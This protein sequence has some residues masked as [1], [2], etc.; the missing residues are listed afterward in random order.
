M[1]H[2]PTILYHWRRS[3]TTRAYSIRDVDRCVDA[4]RR[5]VTE[6][7]ATNDIAADVLPAPAAPMWQRIRYRLPTPAPKVSAIVPTKNHAELLETCVNGLLRNTDYPSL[8]IA[9]VDHDS[10]DMATKIL[11]AKFAK[12]F[13]VRILRYAGLF[14][15]SAINNFA[16]ANTDGDVLAFLNNDIEIMHPDWLREMVSQVMRP[17]IGA[18]GAKL[19]YPD[20]NIQHAGVI[21][22]IGGVAGHQYCHM[23]HD[24]AG[25]NGET[26][27]VRELS[28]V[29]GACMLVRRS[30]FIEAG[31]FD[32]IN[33]P[34]AF[35]DIDFCLRLREHGYRN[36]F[37]PFA[38][39]IHHESASRG[40]EVTPEKQE[41]FRRECEY[42]MGRW[43]DTLQRDPYFNP[44]RSLKATN[45]DL[46][47]PPRISR[48]WETPP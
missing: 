24:F 30:A 19:Y 12:D 35:N 11:L 22:G 4:A 9:I 39:L 6:F 27:L 10:D 34:V 42:M 43:G 18:V 44:N 37:T 36:I 31:G 15:F 41:R 48:P 5:A 32:P 40:V 46:A 29:T 23:P 8:E 13:R 17:G 45:V 20:G 28:A 38:E 25:P 33:L 2:I 47:E 7:L 21:V 26:I 14:N 1:R 16:V 3:D